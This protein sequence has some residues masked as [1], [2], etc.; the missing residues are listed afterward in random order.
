MSILVLDGT[1][2]SCVVPAV[3]SHVSC[4]AVKNEVEPLDCDVY[5]YAA[6]ISGIYSAAISYALQYKK[7][8]RV[9][10]CQECKRWYRYCWLTVMEQ[11]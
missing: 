5:L 6:I 2:S 1:G 7:M 8:N 3:L 4:N 10:S 11:G 9:S